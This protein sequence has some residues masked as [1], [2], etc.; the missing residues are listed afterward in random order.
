MPIGSTIRCPYRIAPPEGPTADYGAYIARVGGCHG[1]HGETLSGG[2]IPAGDPSW[3][4]AANLTP[5]GIGRYSE[6][7]FNTPLR[8]G[9]RPDGSEV[10]VA[11]PIRW[12]KEMTDVEIKAVWEFL[13]GVPAKEFGNR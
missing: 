7:A 8:T 4:P 13:R 9:L 2:P 11:M 5:T 12:S 3:P 10:N 6:T 1:C